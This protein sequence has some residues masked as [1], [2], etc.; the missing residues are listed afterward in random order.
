MIKTVEGKAAIADAMKMVESA[1]DTPERR[2]FQIL[3]YY[4]IGK[5]RALAELLEKRSIKPV[6]H[7]YAV[8]ESAT[9]LEAKIAA[10]PAAVHLWDDVFRSNIMHPEVLQFFV[11]L[12][13]GVLPF[14]GTCILVAND[15]EFPQ[16]RFP[17]LPGVH[18]RLSNEEMI[19]HLEEEMKRRGQT[20]RAM[21]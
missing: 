18:I 10:D 16:F 12:E 2:V 8:I 5:R 15:Q 4:G 14:T 6:E 1:L 3:G 21:E 11:D 13:A 19:A 17:P 9:P 7:H 20:D